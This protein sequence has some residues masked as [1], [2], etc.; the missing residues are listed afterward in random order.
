MNSA[1]W[2]VVSVLSETLRFTLLFDAVCQHRRMDQGLL[3]ANKLTGKRIAEVDGRV[4]P[5]GVPRKIQVLE[6]AATD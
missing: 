6:R 3:L 5:N 1:E 4:Q 2:R